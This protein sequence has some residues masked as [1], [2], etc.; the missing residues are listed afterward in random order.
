MR[1]ETAARYPVVLHSRSTIRLQDDS[2]LA[3]L[4]EIVLKQHSSFNGCWSGCLRHR[5]DWL[6]QRFL[7]PTSVLALPL[8]QPYPFPSNLCVHVT[9]IVCEESKKQEG[10]S[11]RNSKMHTKQLTIGK[12]MHA[13]TDIW[14]NVKI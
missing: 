1:V 3:I 13:C 5:D 7:P 12:H 2:H 6:H 14:R 4:L 8:V 11:D 10:R 9:E